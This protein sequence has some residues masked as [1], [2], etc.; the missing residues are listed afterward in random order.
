MLNPDPL[1]QHA[2]KYVLVIHD[3]M[4]ITT[5]TLQH[6]PNNKAPVTLSKSNYDSNLETNYEVEVNR[7]WLENIFVALEISQI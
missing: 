2:T 1:K 7:C 4:S 5:N 6:C 3:L